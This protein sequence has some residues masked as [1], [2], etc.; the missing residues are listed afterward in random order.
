MYKAA[1]VEAYSPNMLPR[2]EA[3]STGWQPGIAEG[4][5]TCRTGARKRKKWSACKCDFAGTKG[6]LRHTEF[7]ATDTQMWVT[8]DTLFLS[9]GSTLFLTFVQRLLENVRFQCSANTHKS[10]WNRTLGCLMIRGYVLGKCARVFTDE[11]CDCVL[12]IGCI[13]N[14]CSVI[15]G[16]QRAS[17]NANL[18]SIA[19]PRL[20]ISAPRILAVPRLKA[21][22]Q[23]HLRKL[24][25]LYIYFYSILL[26][27]DYEDVSRSID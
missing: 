27:I 24:V 20:G 11:S 16:N 15:E 26:K 9:L 6:S 10:T 7:E 5:I 25:F 4:E 22:S 18:F 8:F 17:R 3:A 12:S 1:P 23:S 13:R 14:R 2:N 21:K 19:R